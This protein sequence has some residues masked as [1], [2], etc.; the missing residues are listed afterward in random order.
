MINDEKYNIRDIIT[1]NIVFENQ[2]YI[3]NIVDDYL[4][5][6]V[7][8]AFTNVRITIWNNVGN[9]VWTNLYNELNE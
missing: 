7:G 5:G 8:Y 4:I 9:I 3:R 6:Y 1:K 2:I